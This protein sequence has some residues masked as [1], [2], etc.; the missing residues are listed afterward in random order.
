MYN[1]DLKQDEPCTTCL[2]VAMDAAYSG[3]FSWFDDDLSFVVDESFDG[4][5]DPT[6]YIPY[7]KKG[8]DDD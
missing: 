2:D 3:D 7:P 4:D 1:E 8:T 6:F 5:S